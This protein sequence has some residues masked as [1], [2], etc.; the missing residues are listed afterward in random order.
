VAP[1]VAQEVH[2][3]EAFLASAP[4]GASPT[5]ALEHPLDR[6]RQAQVGIADHQPSASEAKLYCFAEACGYERAQKLTTEG[7][8]LAV[9]HGVGEAFSEGVAQNFLN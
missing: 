7:L 2:P 9:A 3:A 1:Q 4:P 5:A 6:R 8:C